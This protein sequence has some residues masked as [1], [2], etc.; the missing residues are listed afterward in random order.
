M[1]KVIHTDK[2]PAAVGP[3]SQ[4]ILAGNTL[5]VS[6]Q[7]PLDPKTGA[8]EAK[9]IAGQARQSLTNLQNILVEAGFSLDDVVKTTCL[10]ADINDFGAFNA[11][12]GE[13][14]VNTKPARA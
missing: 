1:N 14:F 10:L 13:F 12:Y 6:G 5:Y 9:D 11:V 4:A 3:Y 2:A 7:I 8:I